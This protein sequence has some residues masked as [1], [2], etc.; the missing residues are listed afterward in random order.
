LAITDPDIYEMDEYRGIDVFV[1][2]T[3]VEREV[4]GNRLFRVLLLVGAGFAIVIA[5]TF[6]LLIFLIVA[7]LVGIDFISGAIY[8]A[9]WSFLILSI[10]SLGFIVPPIFDAKRRDMSLGDIGIKSDS[11]VFDVLLGLLFGGVM[12]TLNFIVTYLINSTVGIPDDGSGQMFLASDPIELIAWIG[13]MFVVVGFSEE[14][15]FRG[16]LQRRMEIY[17]RAKNKKYRLWALIITSFI[18]AA[19]HL[20]PIGLPVRF[21]LGVFLGYLAQ[22]RKYSI[23]G[24]TVAHGFNNAAVVILVSMGF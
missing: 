12:L 18:F 1:P 17:F 23:L 4:D 5:I 3:L 6:V 24:P 9:P 21:M 16:F 19:I 20:D 14:L 2:G 7:G 8:F 10:A 13:V 15:L 11:P 22:K